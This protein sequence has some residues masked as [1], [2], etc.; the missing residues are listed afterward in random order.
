MTYRFDAKVCRTC[1]LLAR[2]MKQPP[3]RHGRTVRKTEFQVEHDRARQKTSTVQYAAVRRE[4]PKV[5]RKLGE[6]MNRHSG[7]RARYR[8]RW[9]VLIQ[10]LMACTATNVKRLA[11]LHCAPATNS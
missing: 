1:P 4:H 7:R 6:L 2:C 11:R 10:E 9:K 5:E 8:G 3:K